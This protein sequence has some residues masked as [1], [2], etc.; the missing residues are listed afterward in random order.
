MR[1]SKFTESQII[2]AIKANENGQRVEDL[3]R[4]LGIRAATFYAWRK[5]YSGVGIARLCPTSGTMNLFNQ[6]F[7]EGSSNLR[8][9]LQ[10]VYYPRPE[11]KMSSGLVFLRNPSFYETTSS[12]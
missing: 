2:K 5:K 7:G 8:P 6:G 10:N 11:D 3:C 12:L 9:F 1:K 4:E